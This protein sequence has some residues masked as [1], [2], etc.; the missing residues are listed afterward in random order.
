MS[1]WAR[2]RILALAPDAASV[3]P[4]QQLARAGRWSDTGC[5]ERALWGRCQGSGRTPYQTVVDLGPTPAYACS[6]P[7]RKLPC[8]HALALLLRWSGGQVAPVPTEAGFAAEWL[9]ARS[10]R[11][12]SGP[13]TPAAVVDPEAA[14]RRAAARADKVNAG[15]DDLELWLH[16]Q[17]RSGLAGVERAGYA[18]FD[19]V[20][21]RMVDAQAPG[22]ATMLRSIPA[23]LASDG[24]PA[25]VLERLAA[26]H[27]LV[28]AHRQLDT[29][30]A[31]LAAN[32]RSRVGYPVAKAEVLA[33]PGVRDHWMALGSVDTVEY[34]L[35]SRRVW[36]YG[37]SSGRWALW[38]TFAA[39]G[40]G[41]DNA[42]VPGQLLHADLHFYPGSGFRAVLG[43]ELD[44]TVPEPATAAALPTEDFA[45][46]VR[47]FA[48]LLARDPW[49]SRMPALVAAAPAAPERPAGPW[50]L[51]DAAGHCVD[52]LGL[53]GDPWPLLARAGGEPV[54]IFGEWTREGLRPLSVLPDRH[55]AT[56]S[57]ALAA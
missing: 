1:V 37:T 53:Q 31:E 4:A 51:R 23:E 16:D 43:E 19:R 27:L 40:A 24:W 22:L 14:A 38:L 55:G 56:F 7:S 10:A 8:K 41:L 12:L 52:L 46:V 49:A 39:P 33:Q 5:T 13:E 6:C 18:H 11:S 35:E 30:P 3:V 34:Q 20:A 32:V 9:R 28:R 42:V 2:E 15:L 48:G 45:E 36:L 17:I 50:R 47:R 21:A 29:L 25:R 54:A 57:T 26:L 44:A